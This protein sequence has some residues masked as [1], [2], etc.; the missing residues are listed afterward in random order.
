MRTNLPVT[1]NEYDWSAEPGVIVSATDKTG[2]ISYVNDIFCRIAG[3]TRE[4]LIGQE[5]NIIRHPD[6]PAEAFRDL[7]RTIGHGKPWTGIVKNR[8]KNGDHYW[9]VAHAAPI[10]EHGKIVGYLSVRTMPSRDQIQ[11]AEAAYAVLNA[12][13]R[14]GKRKTFLQEGFVV[15]NTLV[16]RIKRLT[17]LNTAGRMG[18]AVVAMVLAQFA[19]GVVVTQTL[20][21]ALLPS[22]VAAVVG[23]L[24]S[25]WLY[26]KIVVPLRGLVAMTNRIATGDL[27]TRASARG[28]SLR[29][30]EIGAIARALDQMG[31]NLR[32]LIT[33]VQ[34][35]IRGV[36]RTVEEVAQGGMG[37]A[38]R[39]QSQADSLTDAAAAVEQLSGAVAQN[40]HTASG[41]NRVAAEAREIATAGGT[42][43]GRVVQSMHDIHGASGRMNEII[44]VIES[45][46]FQTNILALNAAVEAAR[47]GEQGRGFAVVASEVRM[48]AQRSS[49]AAREIKTLIDDSAGIVSD[50]ESVVGEAGETIDKVVGSVRKVS[51]LINEITHASSEQE[52]GLKRISDVV[53]NIDSSTHE[54]AALAR[55]S[56]ESANDLREKAM[57]L[58]ETV[59]LFRLG[60]DVGLGRNPEADR[61]RAN[62]LAKSAPRS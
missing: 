2:R 14:S 23:A 52:I 42:A 6:V 39:S 26:R 29:R 27:A 1:Q 49:Q 43:V 37:L 61:A 24:T 51:E 36:H 16:G 22:L 4:E 45:I 62:R 17:H 9:V 3:F 55:Q 53:A 30:D 54:N 15:Q 38:S 40:A 56:A 19:A 50:G 20:H 34:D 10:T 46:A 13:A 11:A 7:W 5:H 18:I 35:G 33:E 44:Q 60:D 58:H 32:A 47:A 21:D 8:C 59:G 57:R 28:H 48:L 31:V 12:E 41:I 25:V